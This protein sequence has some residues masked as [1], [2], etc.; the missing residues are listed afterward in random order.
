MRKTIMYIAASLNGF[1]AGRRNDDEDDDDD[2]YC[3]ISITKS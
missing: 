3:L 1:V 2:K